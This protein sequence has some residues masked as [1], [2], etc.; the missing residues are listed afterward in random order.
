MEVLNIHSD[1]HRINTW[2]IA[3]KNFPENLI[4]SE[5]PPNIF[6]MRDHGVVVEGTKGS[7]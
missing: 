4:S 7:L 2:R 5:F 6:E 1:V 3:Q